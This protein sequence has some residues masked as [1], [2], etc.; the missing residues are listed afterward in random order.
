MTP[1]LIIAL[2]ALLVTVLAI[3]FARR[4]RARRQT[5]L[6]C[7]APTGTARNI[8]LIDPNALDTNVTVLALRKQPC[9][10]D[11]HVVANA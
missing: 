10:G 4:A 11:V 7:K 8:L 6:A 3:L 2:L 1:S 9:V 5:A